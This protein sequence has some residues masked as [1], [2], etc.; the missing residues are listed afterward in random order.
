MFNGL[1]PDRPLGDRA[2]W[3]RPVRGDTSATLWNGTHAYHELPRVLD[4]P[5][6]WVQNANEPP[7]TAT[8]PV[9]LHP[10]AFPAYM[11][12]RGMGLRP[13]RSVR[14]LMEN[15]RMTLEEMVRLKHSTRLELADRVLDNLIAAARASDFADARRA[16]DV[17]ER[18]GR[19]ADA[20]SR[21]T[22]L[23]RVGHR[24]WLLGVEVSAT[25]SR[26]AGLCRTR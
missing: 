12:P 2:F 20:E 26:S 3:A 4:L 11:A 7:W 15:P 21:G 14:M 9:L 5:N 1:I 13:Q 24:R 16:A 8:V 17:L 6:G 18:W 23:S 10:D 25:C 19:S 22:V